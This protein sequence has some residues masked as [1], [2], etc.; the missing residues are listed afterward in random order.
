MRES[1]GV[2]VISVSMSDPG[3]TEVPFKTEIPD[4]QSNRGNNR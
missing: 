2:I 4:F 1:E 3:I